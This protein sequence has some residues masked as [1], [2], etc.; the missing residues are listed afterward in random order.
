MYAAFSF[1]L[2]CLFNIFPVEFLSLTFYCKD[3]FRRSIVLVFRH[4][5]SLNLLILNLSAVF[6][7]LIIFFLEPLFFDSELEKNVFDSI[8]PGRAI[9]LRTWLVVEDSG[10]HFVAYID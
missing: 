9:L 5:H 10:V 6:K 7:I 2:I 4:F 3:P 1:M 8:E